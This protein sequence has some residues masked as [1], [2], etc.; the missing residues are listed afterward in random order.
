MR[1]YQV[2]F[3]SSAALHRKLHRAIRIQ[4]MHVCNGSETMILRY[5]HVHS[6]FRSGT[7]VG[8]I[9]LHNRGIYRLNQILD[10]IRVQ[11]VAGWRFTGGQLYRDVS[12]W[13]SG[14]SVVNSHWPLG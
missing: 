14:Q 11:I 7:A 13:L 6:R 9:A 2:G 4:N 1:P 5:L 8:C 12:G 3:Q 10:Q